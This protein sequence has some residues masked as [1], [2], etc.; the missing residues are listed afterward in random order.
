MFDTP[1]L[2]LHYIANIT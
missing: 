1:I 2:K